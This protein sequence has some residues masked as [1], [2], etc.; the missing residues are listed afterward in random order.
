LAPLGGDSG[1]H[2][3]FERGEAAVAIAK[4]GAG[5]ADEVEM[6]AVNVVVRRDV[7]VYVF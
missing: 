2:L 1:V 3:R 6:H 4:T 7:Q 5:V